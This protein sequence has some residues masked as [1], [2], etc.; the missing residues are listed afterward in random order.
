VTRGQRRR[1]F[2]LLRAGGDVWASLIE[3][4]RARF[5]GGGRPIAS[6]QEWC[7]EIAGVGVGEL[8]VT[9][10]RSVVG[11]Y[12][13]AFMETA[14][15]KRRG[16]RARYPRRKRALFPIR[17]Y[18]DT[19][20]FEGRRV[21]L[22]VARGCPPLWVRLARPVPYPLEQVRSVT[23]VVEAGRVS[24]DVTAAVPVAHHDLDPGRVAGVDVGIIHPFAAAS[25]DAAIVISGRA[26]RAEERLHLAD[27]KGRARNAARRAP[28]PGQRGSR[29]WRR[30][31]VGQRRAEAKHRRRIRH[32]HHQAAKALVEWAIEHRVGSLAVG[33]LAGITDRKVGRRQNRQLRQWRRTHL[34]GALRDKAEAAGIHV[35]VVD[36]RHTSSTCPECGASTR[37]RG[38]HFTCEHCGH[39]SHRDVVGARN[40]AARG[41]GTTRTPVRVT[42]RRAGTVPARRDRRRHQMDV[43]RSSLAHGRPRRPSRLGSRSP[44]NPSRRGLHATTVR[45]HA[46]PDAPDEDPQPFAIITQT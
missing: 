4:N 12:C 32:A 15:R 19:F 9:G 31:R 11:R 6:Y 43:R 44:G 34:V 5:R 28:K 18:H 36:E 2:G 39:R 37:P 41:G 10:M 3:V 8:S 26:L 25:D 20:A 7:R 17:W 23:L 45:V 40:I 33:D 27:T 14:R 30:Y 16:E 46:H 24:L 38:R 22:S 29:R 21:R 35:L 13:D 42:H 1:C